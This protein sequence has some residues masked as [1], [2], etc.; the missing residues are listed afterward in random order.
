M[1]PTLADL[2]QS[3]WRAALLEQRTR[4]LHDARTKRR[5]A[6]TSP[7]NVWWIEWNDKLRQARWYPDREQDAIADMENK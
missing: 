4:D 6:M 1:A 2:I 7:K 5:T 3:Y